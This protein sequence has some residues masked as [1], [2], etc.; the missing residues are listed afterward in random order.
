MAA[1]PKQSKDKKVL[2]YPQSI[3]AEETDYLAISVVAYKPI[4]QT[5]GPNKTAGRLIGKA[6]AR[7][8]SKEERIKT[9]ILPI[10][11]NI[12]D[13]NAAK[14]GDSSLNTIA[15]TAIGG[16]ADIMES[17]KALGGGGDFIGAFSNALKNAAT[18]TIGAAGGLEGAQGFATRML[19]SE[20]A[21][22]LGA[23]ITPDQILARTSGEILNPNL[24]LLFGGPTLRSFRFSFK[25]TPRNQSEAQEVK[26]II[27]CFKMNMAPKVKGA[28]VSIEGTMMKTPNVF[29][30]R[31]KQGADDHKFLNRFKQC[32][33][34]TI[35]V[36]YTA[37]GTY[38]TYENGEPVSM[39]MDLSFKEIEPIYDVDYEDASS[40]TGVGY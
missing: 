8:N 4:S 6:G 19:A 16:I 7:R 1:E 31:Y 17:G 5:P 37:D 11:S 32:F 22:I 12:S 28:D 2:R 40:G 26:Q 20:A 3:I 25:F 39:I 30:L 13:T 15:A 9:I 38:A 14:F 23:N 24:E 18:S 34:E 33:L 35:S 29:E 10:P 21:G 27:R 36:N